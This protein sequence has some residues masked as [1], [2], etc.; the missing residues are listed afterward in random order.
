MQKTGFVR[1]AEIFPAAVSAI[2]IVDVGAATYTPI[3]LF[4]DCFAAIET[5][6]GLA[7]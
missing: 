5:N 1:F 4:A 3:R 2:E 6:L 7:T